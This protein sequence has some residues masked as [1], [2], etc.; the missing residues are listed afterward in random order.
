VINKSNAIPVKRQGCTLRGLKLS[1]NP[2]ARAMA[3]ASALL[4]GGLGRIGRPWRGGNRR[5]ALPNKET[6]LMALHT[7]SAAPRFNAGPKFSAGQRVSVARSG[8]FSVPG[9]VYRVV[10]ALPA[11]AGPP[12]YRIRNEAETFDRV[13]TESRLEAVGPE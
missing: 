7:F 4:L 10:N 3:N 2:A 1:R 12:Q 11:E 5:G 8:N 6:I 9:G 13:I